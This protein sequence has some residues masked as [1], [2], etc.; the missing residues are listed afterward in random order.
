M[1][2]STFKKWL[3]L[4]VAAFIIAVAMVGGRLVFNAFYSE[5]D[6]INNDLFM[7]GFGL[8]LLAVTFWLPIQKTLYAIMRCTKKTK[9]AIESL[10]EKTSKVLAFKK[11]TGQQVM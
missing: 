6:S 11:E 10:V 1:T 9:V 7:Q 5:D 4:F 2:C 3:L 8:I